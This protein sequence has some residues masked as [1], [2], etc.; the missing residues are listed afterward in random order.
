LRSI[1]TAR[2]DELRQA[3]AR[4]VR[5][6]CL[7]EGSHERAIVEELPA[8]DLVANPEEHLL[9]PSGTREVALT[10]RVAHPRV[11]ERW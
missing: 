8:D 3:L 5:R 9:L 1:S 7:A 11:G 10:N 4:H 2:I 6:D